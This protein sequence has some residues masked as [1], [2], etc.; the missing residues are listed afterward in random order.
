M[1]KKRVGGGAKKKSR[2]GA[3]V[4]SMGKGKKILEKAVPS[5]SDSSRKHGG[6]LLGVSRQTL[7][8][9]S[10]RLKF[11]RTDEQGRVFDRYGKRIYQEGEEQTAEES[12]EE[13]EVE[14]G[15]E[16]LP[17]ND[18]DEEDTPLKEI[19]EKQWGMAKQGKGEAILEWTPGVARE[20]GNG[21]GDNGNDDD[22][23]DEQEEDDED[24][25][26]SEIQALQAKH[27]VA[28][29][30]RQQELAERCRA[31]VLKIRQA[32]EKGGR[33]PTPK[34]KTSKDLK[35]KKTSK[36]TQRG[37]KVIAMK[38]PRAP[39]RPMPSTSRGGGTGV[40]KLPTGKGALPSK[41]GRSARGG[42]GGAS[43]PVSG[44]A[45][46]GPSSGRTRGVVTGGEQQKKRKYRPGTRALME[47]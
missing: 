26:E 17:E 14:L 34:R 32:T 12:S 29:L 21:D 1:A 43:R 47:I 41:K 44:R 11:Y 40:K 3:T 27:E 10:R 18:S 38:V 5:K 24:V 45:G 30:C 23:D 28:E 36:T 6:M 19:A 35:T 13:E 16:E 20:R 46:G 22:G 25:S 4:A 39:A 33:P 42:G 2:K 37:K 9:F 31:E 15:V 7:V 8:G